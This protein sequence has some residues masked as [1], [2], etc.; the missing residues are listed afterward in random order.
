MAIDY[1]PVDYVVGMQPLNEVETTQRHAFGT[2]TRAKDATYGEAQFV[3]VKGVSSGAAGLAVTYVPHTGVTTLTGARSKGLVA[4]LYTAL[5]ATTK[6]G[7][8]QIAGPADTQVAGTVAASN[9]V[10]LTSTG[11]KLDDAVVA[12]DIVYGANFATADGTPS[13][14]H[15]MI[16]LSRPYVGDTDNT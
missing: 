1:K 2:I 6:F 3:Y 4:V 16:S 10:Y 7:W 13:A 15:A 12:G 11:G 9:T 5:D 8:A 14:N